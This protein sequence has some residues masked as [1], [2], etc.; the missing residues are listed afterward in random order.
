AAVKA[1]FDKSAKPYAADAFAATSRTLDAYALGWVAMHTD[2][3]EAT[4]VRGTQSADL[5]DLRMEC[6]Q[7]RLD[8]V[9][10]QV[11]LFAAADDEVISRAAEMT[12]K[13]PPLTGCADAE[14]LRAPVRPPANAGARK[15]VDALRKELATVR[16]LWDG[17]RYAEA[18]KRVQ[19]ALAGARDLGY[20]PLEAEA[21]LMHGR[22]ADSLG[23]YPTAVRAFRD[24]VVAAE[25]GRHDEVA[26]LAETRLVWVTTLQEKLA[27]AHELARSAQAKIDRIGH[28]EL[29]QAGL[30]VAVASLFLEEGK[31]QEAE[32]R[33]KR[34][35]AVREK[36]LA[37]DDVA[38]AGALGDLGDAAVQLGHYK[39]AIER[40]QRAISIFEHS[41]GGEHPKVGNLRVNLGAALRSAGRIAEALVEYKRAQGI[42]ERSLGRDHPMLASIDLNVGAVLL[43]QGREA[44]AASQ[45]K[46]AIEIST[47][48]LGADHPNVGTA[49]YRL[50]N[51][52][53]K[54]GRADEG[55]ADFQKAYDIWAAKLGA[56]HPTLSAALDGLGDAQLALGKPAAAMSYYKRALALLE[57]TV[58]PKHPDL[59][60]ALIGIGLT[61]LATNAP[62]RAVPPLERA[63]A[64]RETAGDP[65]EIARARFALARALAQGGDR[66]RAMGLADE[67][68]AVYA[69]GDV[70][71]ARELVEIDHWLRIQRPHH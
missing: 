46:R 32:E 29:L 33:S 28:P 22:L 31:Y 20:R 19:P 53:L 52:A 54:Q 45:F 25:A 64:L 43:D 51:V 35:L 69:K 39:E 9:R 68:R 44:E 27:D 13:L 66:T 6:L 57:K 62:R 42:I 50:G 2:A 8:D 56:E 10:A 11:D 3:C 7:Q 60:D 38:I 21:L 26:A 34:V 59:A 36:T 58:G 61:E 67:A 47:R 41:V 1:A 5:M 23:D 14:A 18:E 71:S 40:Y 49:W 24:A 63:L 17:G 12:R 55:R 37:P 48:A 70:T 16:A 30:D 15:R 4:R 65:L